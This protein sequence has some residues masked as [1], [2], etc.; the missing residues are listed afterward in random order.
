MKIQQ[1]QFQDVLIIEPGAF[2]DKREFFMETSHQEK[3]ERLG[4]R[5]HFVKINLSYSDRDRGLRC[6]G[7]KHSKKGIFV[8]EIG[9]RQKD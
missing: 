7:L 4:I 5:T 1:T 3:Y 6:L 9:T 2:P 8:T